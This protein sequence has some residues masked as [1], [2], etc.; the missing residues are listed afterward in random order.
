[1]RCILLSGDVADAKF[2][3]EAVKRTIDEFGKL[4]VLVNNAA[5]QEHVNKFEDLTEEHFDRTLKTN[6][7]GYFHMAKAAVPKMKKGNSIVMTGSVTGRVINDSDARYTSR[8]LRA[9]HKR[10]RHRRA[11][12]QRDEVAP[13]HCPVSPV[14]PTERIAHLGPAGGAAL[15]DF[16]AADV[17]IESQSAVSGF[18][19]H[20]CFTPETGHWLARLA[21][22]KSAKSSRT[23]AFASRPDD[24]P[25]SRSGYCA[26]QRVKIG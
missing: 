3:K 16:E 21:R 20:G 2:C 12:E 8:L 1:V 4:D 7:Y 14:L 6:L 10:P 24:Q 9:R 25:C 5:F 11:A 13:F 17:R 22:Q 26:G 15:R 18:L 19:R 23:T